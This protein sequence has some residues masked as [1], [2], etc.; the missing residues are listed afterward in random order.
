L[1]DVVDTDVAVETVSVLAV[2]VRVDAGGEDELCA[3]NRIR[4][5][6]DSL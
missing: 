4:N 3:I 1:A 6:C 5:E 2:L